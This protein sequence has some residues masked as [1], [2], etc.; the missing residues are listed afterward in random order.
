M[1]AFFVVA[2][3]TVTIIG[4]LAIAVLFCVFII[5]RVLGYPINLR[6]EKTRRK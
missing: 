4:L 1:N 3:V 5:V 2:G 6:Y